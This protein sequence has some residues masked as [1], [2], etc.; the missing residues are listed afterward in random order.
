MPQNLITLPFDAHHVATV[1][2]VVGQLEGLLAPLVA[3][4]PETRRNV[5]QR[6]QKS[7]QFCRLT[8]NALKLNPK[9]VPPT[10]GLDDAH[11]DLDMLDRL[12]PL[13]QRLHRLSERASD[14]ELALGAD[15]MS[16]ALAGYRVFRAVGRD[17]GLAALNKD[18]G[19]RFAGR[20]P[21]PAPEA[22]APEPAAA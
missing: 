3:L 7:E 4:T 21:A 6:G 10:I 11:F 1:E 17:E 16:A 18:L 8:L 14:S 9:V 19:K 5:P 12:R 22:A 13:F 20:R 2:Q 15:V